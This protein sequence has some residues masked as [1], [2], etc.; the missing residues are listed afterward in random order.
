MEKS[1][2]N[3]QTELVVLNTDA[4]THVKGGGVIDGMTSGV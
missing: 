1:L 3:L 4:Q 2:A